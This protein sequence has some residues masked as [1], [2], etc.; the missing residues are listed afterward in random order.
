MIPGA[1]YWVLGTG[2]WVL[3]AG[4]RLLDFFQVFPVELIYLLF[5]KLWF[6]WG[7]FARQSIH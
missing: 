2:Y 6:Y 1:G 7:W 5:G 4:S 3:G